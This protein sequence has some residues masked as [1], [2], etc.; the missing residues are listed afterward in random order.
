MRELAQFAMKGPRYAAGIALVACMVPMMFWIGAATLAL[1]TLRH[2]ASQGLNVFAWAAAPSLAWW[3]GLHDPTAMV[4]LVSTF[5]MA[6]VLRA[7]VSMRK[8][9]LFGF[10]FSVVFGVLTP[11]IMPSTIELL[12]S[13]TDEI[14]KQLAV[15]AELEV[16]DELVT[17][18][19]ALLVAS[20]AASFF[21]MSIG[22]LFLARW[23]QAA[24]FNPGGWREEFHQLRLGSFEM[25]VIIAAMLLGPSIGLDGYILVFSG[26]VPIVVCGLALVHGLVGK[27]NLGGHW[28]VGFYV[29]TVVLFPTLIAIVVLLAML[30]SAIDIRSRVQ[31]STD[32]E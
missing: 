11:L 8:T 17:S 12:L 25:A 1:V 20:F 29:L 2:G 16:T 14:L 21:A 13:L 26:L 31:P 27:K 6:M 30:D 22:S 15:D 23:W 4:V 9:L 3:L 10:G 24:L 19:Q 18:F 7:S 32:L 5:A 28:M